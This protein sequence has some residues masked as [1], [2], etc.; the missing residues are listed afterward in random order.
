[1][2]TDV[3]LD[4]RD[5]WTLTEQIIFLDTRAPEIYAEAHIPGAI[6]V[7]EFFTCEMMSNFSSIKKF[8]ETFVDLINCAG[9]TGKERAVVYEDAM[10]SGNGQ[11]SRAYYIL[12][13]LGYPNV[14]IIH[15]GFKAWL[16]A[17]LPVDKSVLPV[18]RGSF[19]PVFN[20]SFFATKDD[21]KKVLKDPHVIKLDVRDV[22]EWLGHKVS[23]IAEQMPLMHTGRIP[24]AVW[25]P[26]RSFL[27]SDSNGVSHFKSSQE[28]SSICE[29]AGIAKNSQV[30]VYCYKGSRAA[31]SMLCMQLAGFNEIKNYFASWSEWGR[32]S[33]LAFENALV[34][35][36]SG[37]AASLSAVS[38][39]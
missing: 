20:E 7:R 31:S 8:Q 30:Y 37:K 17:K 5:A 6:N 12:K 2:K 15:G 25:I 1:M 11:S 38:A 33:S 22:D 29:S 32:D 27:T 28:I 23:P 26:W 9:F 36:T 4:P 13:Y 10:D 16:Q 39:L 18:I 21:I 19:L 24:G 34:P 35:G 14:S 3:L